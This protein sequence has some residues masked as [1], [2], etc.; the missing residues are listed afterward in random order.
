MR[1]HALIASCAVMLFASACDSDSESGESS[2]ADAGERT[3]EEHKDASSEAPAQDASLAE[4]AAQ[5]A[6]SGQLAPYVMRTEKFTLD[7]GQEQYLCYATTLD[8]D[9]VIGGYS[10][11]AQ[12]FVHHLVFVK[13]L[14]PEPDGFSECDTLFRMTWEPL[15]I[16]GA[17]DAKLEFP[18]D[19]GHKLA[20]GTQLLVQMHLLNVNDE[21]VEG[22][23]EI[24]MHRSTAENPRSVSAFAFGTSDLSLPPN[25]ESEAIGTCEL[26]ERVELIAAFPHMHLLGTKMAVDVGSSED[27]M[28]RVFE[29]DPYDFD[30]QHIEP[31]QLTLEPGDKARVTCG[32]NNTHSE[33]I[34]FGESTN[35]EMCFFIGFALD[36]EGLG[37]C[38]QRR[39]MPKP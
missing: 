37:T 35:T 6:K 20:K 13:P 1:C 25:Q 29:R 36:R 10:S 32:Y 5:S 21:P 3:H 22:S 39:E 38:T 4:K 18:K 9:L 15:Y 27:E 34:G 17:G 8:E 16:T 28:K 19:A 2:Q 30:D 7:P 14:A 11:K 33:V 23:V 12:T 24:D 26:K 31:L